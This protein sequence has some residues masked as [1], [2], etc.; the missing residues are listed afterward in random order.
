MA[1]ILSKIESCIPSLRRYAYALLRSSPDADDLVQE[2]LLRALDGL[3]TLRGEEDVRPWLFAIMHNTFVNHRRRARV[4]SGLVPLAHAD[5][6]ALGRPGGQEDRLHWRDLVQAL[7]CLPDDQR[8]VVLLVSVE[9]LTYAET[10][11]AL[12]VPIGTVMSRLARARERLRR[13]IQQ[14]PEARPCLRRVK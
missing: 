4:R 1:G 10:A 8:E 12:D 7:A 3:H 5:D 2:T 9:D 11:R 14:E 13:T 6:V